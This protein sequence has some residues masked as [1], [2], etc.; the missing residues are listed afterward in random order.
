MGSPDKKKIFT[1]RV[2]P[3][4][5]G[6][7]SLLRPGESGTSGLFYDRLADGIRP[8]GN[9]RSPERGAALQQCVTH[10]LQGRFVFPALPGPSRAPAWHLTGHKTLTAIRHQ[11]DPLLGSSVSEYDCQR[12]RAV[13]LQNS[14]DHRNG[15]DEIFSAF[16]APRV[17][18]DTRPSSAYG[19]ILG[20]G[21][22]TRPDPARARG[23]TSVGQFLKQCHHRAMSL[24]SIDERIVAA[25]IED[26]RASYATI[27]GL[28]GLSAPA[29]KRRVDRLQESGAIRGF[30]ARVD[31]AALGWTTEAYV[32]LFCRA[33]TSPADIR[34]A[35]RRF[36][37]VVGACTVTGEADALLHIQ[38]AD[39]GHFEQVVERIRAEPFTTRTRSVIVMSRL[40]D[41]TGR[42]VPSA[43]EPGHSS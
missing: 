8:R 40:V 19:R 24:D 5:G 32:E 15:S 17:P 6:G 4:G 38:A 28:V 43:P 41:R 12:Y 18:E 22:E 20:S 14:C 1:R 33:L 21:M 10:L 9:S 36:P 29:V 13:D 37:E 3:P 26:A 30:S 7:V 27:G 23:S 39:V 11:Q 42:P 16:R 31:P 25:L 2:N 34:A 35:V